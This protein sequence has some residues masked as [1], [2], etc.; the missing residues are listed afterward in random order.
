MTYAALDDPVYY[1]TAHKYRV[2]F[3]TATA[4]RDGSK[5]QL[6]F[7]YTL[8]TGDEFFCTVDKTAYDTVSGIGCVRTTST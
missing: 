4:L 2:S 6:D 1:S 8:P 3:T 5:I 7:G